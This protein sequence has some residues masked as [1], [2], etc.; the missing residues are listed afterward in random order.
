MI[1]HNKSYNIGEN[2]SETNEALPETNDNH[3]GE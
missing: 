2:V 3:T 1:Q